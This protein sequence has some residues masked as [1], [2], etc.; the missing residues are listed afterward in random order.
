MTYKIHRE[1]SIVDDDST[2][3]DEKGQSGR[4]RGRARGNIDVL[5]VYAYASW[6]IAQVGIIGRTTIRTNIISQKGAEELYLYDN[7]SHSTDFL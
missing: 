5:R 1:G 2:T 3:I 7:T 6:H 4:A